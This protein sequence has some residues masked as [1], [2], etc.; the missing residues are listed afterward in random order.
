MIKVTNEKCEIKD[1]TANC[2]ES[3]LSGVVVLP[4]KLA[5]E[6]ELFLLHINENCGRDETYRGKSMTNASGVLYSRINMSRNEKAI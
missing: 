6:V 5:R 2:S 3:D 4:A 1:C